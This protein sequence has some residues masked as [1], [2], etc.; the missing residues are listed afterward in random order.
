MTAFRT[1]GMH[2][3]ER[4]YSERFNYGFNVYRYL[5]KDT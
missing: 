3:A 2:I 4:Q 1:G 5:Y